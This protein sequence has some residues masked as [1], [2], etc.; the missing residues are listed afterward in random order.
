MMKPDPDKN[1]DLSHNIH[2][3]LFIKTFS[4]PENVKIFLNLA[5]PK[6]I[7]NALD[8][9]QIKIGFTSYISEDI[10]DYSS[11]LVVKTRMK[12]K[13]HRNIPA[14]I[15][16][17]FELWHEKG[18]T[19]NKEMMIF[20]LTY[21]SYIRD[22]PLEQLKKTLE[23]CHLEGGDIMPSLA[24]RLLE[25]GREQGIAQGRVQ[26]EKETAKEV[27][28]RMLSDDFPIATIVKYTGLT[29]QEVKELM[30]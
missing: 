10:K 14:D 17:I 25:Q 21:V 7:S 12:S 16:A 24:Q 26:G 23:E 13:D 29:E 1:R 8:F 30:N 15:K 5:L 19:D 2:N 28:R 4:D 18:F 9:S 22:V 27:A 11:D 6:Q 20:F 3:N